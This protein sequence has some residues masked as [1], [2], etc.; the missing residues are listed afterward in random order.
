MTDDE[1]EELRRWTQSAAHAAWRQ[2]QSD[3]AR[4]VAWS[5]LHAAAP[6]PPEPAALAEEAEARLRHRREWRA[7]PG[8]QLTGA[9]GRLQSAARDLDHAAERLREAAARG[10]RRAPIDLAP[11]QAAAAQVRRAERRLRAAVAPGPRSP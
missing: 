10:G 6:P 9:L 3:R 4:G 11:I 8:G 2:G 7:S 1:A 5:G